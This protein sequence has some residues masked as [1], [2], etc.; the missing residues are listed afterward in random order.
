MDSLKSAANSTAAVSHEAKLGMMVIT[1][2]FFA[3]CFLVYHKM[4]LHQRQLASIPSAGVVA[5][6]ESGTDAAATGAKE[7]PAEDAVDP[8]LRVEDL[9]DGSPFA[10][11]GF[12]ADD[13]NSFSQGATES[14]S[15]FDPQLTPAESSSGDNPLPEDNRVSPNPVETEFS[16]VAAAEANS[17]GQNPNSS[18]V[19]ES[20][21]TS[22]PEIVG[23][24]EQHEGQ[25]DN[26]P[27]GSFGSTAFQ[28]LS[29]SSSAEPAFPELQPA[30]DTPGGDESVTSAVE[31]NPEDPEPIAGGFNAQ[32][33]RSS[34]SDSAQFESV[35]AAD[36]QQQTANVPE[37][38]DPDT[39]VVPLPRDPTPRTQ[40]PAEFTEFAATEPEPVDSRSMTVQTESH[41]EPVMIAMAE[42][43]TDGF[44]GGFQADPPQAEPAFP[45]I[46][47]VDAGSRDSGRP[48][49]GSGGYEAVTQP[50]GRSGKSIRTAAGSGA[51][52]DG[53][54]SLAAFN[55]EN[56]IAANE[57]SA[58]NAMYDSVIVQKND[59]YSKISKRV[60]GSIRY[61]SA[62][63][64][65]NQHRITEP[66]HMRP[67]MVVLTPPK[68]VLEE[69]YPQ[70]FVNSASKTSEPAGFLL[71]DDGTPAYRVGERETL[72]EISQRFLGRSSRWIEIYRLNQSIVNDPNRLKSGL[73]LALPDDATEVHVMP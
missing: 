35:A 65:F 2:L 54:F 14:S 70:L 43:Q 37:L 33:S 60:Y 53:K 28:P 42:P 1:I 26:E 50:G 4:E 73:I 64:V 66:K 49:F 47:R 51:D 23:A 17:V 62:L 29:G 9:S 6:H 15:A 40:P 22:E 31:A 3:F 69:K 19:V 72:S 45:A 56:G 39:E 58:D 7:I 36:A 61:F 25:P 21:A 10:G 59:N 24:S 16:T 34:E 63:A 41:A 71:L 32:E 18:S 52:A 44:S 20:V 11:Q 46:D 5:D 12:V 67:G 48:A 57:P 38:T 8:L 55:S 68:E 27:A 13:R 30:T